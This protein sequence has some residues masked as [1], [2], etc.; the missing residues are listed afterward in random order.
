MRVPFCPCCM[1]VGSTDLGQA[2]PRFS[3]SL[4]SSLADVFSSLKCLLPISPLSS[5]SYLY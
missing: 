4:V 5:V 1:F 2:Q 3:V